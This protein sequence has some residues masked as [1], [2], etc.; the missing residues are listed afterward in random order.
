MP[1]QLLHRANVV[2]RLQ[3]VRQPRSPSYAD[4]GSCLFPAN[5]ATHFVIKVCNS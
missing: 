5:T 4:S 1:Q 2:P 3:H